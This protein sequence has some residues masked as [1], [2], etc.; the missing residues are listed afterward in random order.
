MKTLVLSLSETAS[1]KLIV[2]ELD[3]QQSS[4]EQGTSVIVLGLRHTNGCTRID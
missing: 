3:D 2:E 4:I 1:G